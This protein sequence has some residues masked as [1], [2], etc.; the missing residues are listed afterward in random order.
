MKSCLA[1]D[2]GTT[3]T[4]AYRVWSDGRME[5]VGRRSHQQFLPAPGLVE[6]DAEEILR[7]IEELIAE[8]GPVDAL[9]LANQ[10]ETVVAWDAETGVPVG[11]AIVWQDTRTAD[12]V[13]RMKEEGL[14]PDIK[15]RSGLPLD[16]YFSASRLRWYL[17]HVPQA[18]LLREQGRLRFGTSDAFFLDRLCGVFVTDVSTASR[19]SLMN[20]RTCEWDETLCR[21]FDVPME[22]LPS[23]RPTVGAFGL[24]RDR[25]IPVRV[26]AVDQ[27]AALY[28]HGLQH[29]GDVKITFGTGAF[30]LALGAAGVCAGGEGGVLPTVAWRF[31]GRS[32]V[33][34]LEGGILTAGAAV[35]WVES[36]G[37]DFSCADEKA[38]EAAQ[39]AEKGLFF[40]PALQG[41]GCPWWERDARGSWV[42]LGLDTRPAD[43][44]RAVL[45]GIAF[46]SVQLVKTFAAASGQT[47]T[48]ISVDGG[49]VSNRWF[50]QFL[51]NCLGASVHVP[52]Q[53]DVTAAGL[54]RFWLDGEGSQPAQASEAGWRVVTPRPDGAEARWQATF[55]HVT[56]QAIER[57]AKS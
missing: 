16:C 1:I 36:L 25:N 41:L 31:A 32:A 8:A 46:R 52:E 11:P 15:A 38:L 40:L 49:L 42:G 45:E 2:Q 24:L 20:L 57:C 37:P 22:C 33:Y 6:H 44:A 9:A 12:V 43:M 23:I 19:T 28:G 21:L 54:G 4:K 56:R 47:A 39:A 51:A 18:R 30:A 35:N 27:Q 13:A 5:L 3:G 53:V 34:A 29:P 14:E 17:D 26:S 48:R 55:D 7:H 10:G 50:T